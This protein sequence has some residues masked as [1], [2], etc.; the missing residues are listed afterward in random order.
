MEAI[1][2]LAFC[3]GM[4]L[5]TGHRRRC[6]A[7]RCRVRLGGAAVRNPL[8]SWDAA[9]KSRFDQPPARGEISVAFGQCPDRVQVIGQYRHRID[10]ER[11]APAGLAKCA[12][13]RLD[14]LR[15]QT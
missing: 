7:A 8:A 2:L 13:Q 1:Q 9:R 14:V 4:E 15:Q 10:R 11:M 3:A 5:R 12:T 6:Y